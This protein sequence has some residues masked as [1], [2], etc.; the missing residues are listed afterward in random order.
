MIFVDY[1]LTDADI[2]SISDNFWRVSLVTVFTSSKLYPFHKR[3]SGEVK[4]R[5]M[6]FSIRYTSELPSTWTKDP[7]VTGVTGPF[8][9]IEPITKLAGDPPTFTVSITVFVAVSITETVLLPVDS[10]HIPLFHPG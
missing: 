10:S 4:W 9:A 6:P 3:A 8:D 1:S 7:S 5:F 2:L